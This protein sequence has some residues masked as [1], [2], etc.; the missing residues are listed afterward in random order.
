MDNH[1]NFS[2][3]DLEIH[4]SG[5][6]VASKCSSIWVT[7]QYSGAVKNYLIAVSTELINIGYLICTYILSE[8]R[9]YPPKWTSS[10]SQVM[11]KLARLV[12]MSCYALYQMISIS[13]CILKKKRHTIL[14]WMWRHSRQLSEPKRDNCRTCHETGAWIR[15][16]AVHCTVWMPEAM[17]GSITRHN[18]DN[19]PT[20]SIALKVW[21]PES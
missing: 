15:N 7:N 4:S 8:T 18:F 16:E 21:Q 13:T 20:L 19:L 9:F 3:A 17:G 5:V 2:H 10:M 6:H 11:H 12:F 14:F 1:R